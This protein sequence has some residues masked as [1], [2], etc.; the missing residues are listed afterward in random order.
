VIKRSHYE[1]A[2]APPDARGDASVMDHHYVYPRV[3]EV[4]PA[5]PPAAPAAPAAVPPPRGQ[6]ELVRASLERRPGAGARRSASR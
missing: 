6:R 1:P 5:V 3:V 2:K 4:H